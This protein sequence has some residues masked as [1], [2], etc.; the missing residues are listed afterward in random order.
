[1][2]RFGARLGAGSGNFRG[3]SA[4]IT[5]TNLSKRYGA[6]VL[7][8]E[9]NLRLDPQK[10]YGIVGANGAGK[11]TLLR[12]L[13][14]EE[15]PDSGE[16][17]IPSRLRIGTLNQDHF[18]F[19][20]Y[21][22]VDV[23]MKGKKALAEAFEEKEHLLDDPDAPPERFSELEEIIADHDGYMAESR[24]GE[25]LEGLGIPVEKH[26]QPMSTLSGGY[27]L[28]VLLA[29]CLFGD[30]DVLLLDEPTNHLDIYSIKWLEDYLCAYRGVVVVI[31]HDREFL[32]HVCTH[33]LDVDY[34]TIKEYTGN[35][36][37][38]VVGKE[39]DNELRR[40]EAEKAEKKIGELKTFVTRFKAKASKARQAQSK[41]K[42]I[43]RMEKEISE[44]VYSSR[45]YPHIKFVPCRPPGK[46]VLRV[47]DVA[48]SYGEKQVLKNVSFTVFRGDKLAVL[49]PN[50][51]G[52]STL[53]KIA[54]GELASDNG[55][56]EWGHETHP[57]Y[58]SQDHH[59]NMTGS[60]TVHNWL[61]NHAPKE[62]IGAIRGILGNMLFT[63]DDDVHKSIKAL[64]GGEAARL[65]LA[66]MILM[67]GNILVLDE[68]TNH[69]DMESIESLVDALNA[70][71][72]TIILVSHNRYVVER[73]ATKILEVTPEGIDLHTDNYEEYLARVGIDH[74]SYQVD[75]AAEKR[76]KKKEKRD[77]RN[78][79]DDA[80]RRKAYNAEARPLEARNGELEEA[81]AKLEGSIEE[82][83]DLFFDPT[84]FN[85]TD[86]A[87]IRKQNDRKQSL[88][89]ELKKK[90]EEWEAVNLEL[91][92]LK[93][94]HGMD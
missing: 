42:Q 4:M 38:F 37:A 39:A 10:R 78:R 2:V 64:S 20:K 57:Q 91:E 76:D 85:K 43:E 3:I 21:S 35:Y 68:P 32:N 7:F 5:V 9:V 36:D 23:A 84:Y 80:Q 66:R 41:S 65:V 94:K 75:L 93:E 31:S 82:I 72:G 61:H 83:N 45:R 24:I 54:M 11:S 12:I 63:G 22:L 50:G 34:G 62:P 89:G 46:E 58:F 17:N 81:I 51:V 1:M 14:S 28:R 88:E 92:E 67:K 16:V 8:E 44:P 86:P 90:M 69:L 56:V 49:G 25:M 15:Y 52:K 27:K 79:K 59:E 87:E 60:E 53:L 73:V 13:T 18:A 29:Q 74:L 47:E 40:I 71:D 33:T 70:F 77:K 30:P 55:S 48:K 26:Y 19:E 6:Q